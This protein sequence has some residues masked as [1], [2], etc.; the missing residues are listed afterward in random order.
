MGSGDPIPGTRSCRDRRQFGSALSTCR[1]SKSRSLQRLCPSLAAQLAVRRCR[2]EAERFGEVSIGLLIVDLL[3]GPVRWY[4]ALIS[5]KEV[6]SGDFGLLIAF[7]LPGFIVLWGLRYFSATVRLWFSGAGTTPTIGGFMFGTLAS[8]VAG[9]TVT[10]DS[11][12][13]RFPQRNPRSEPRPESFSTRVPLTTQLARQQRFPISALQ[14]CARNSSR[15]SKCQIAVEL[16]VDDT[17]G[18]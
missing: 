9:V 5:M 1:T 13:D 12:Y 14:A 7:V 2:L 8:V 17:V 11:L 10:P 15:K 6:S 4:R 3:L 18:R 16:V